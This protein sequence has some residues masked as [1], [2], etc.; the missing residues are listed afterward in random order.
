MSGATTVSVAG[1]KEKSGCTVLDWASAS[2]TRPD[3]ESG[4]GS[5][6]ACGPSKAGASG[7]CRVGPSYLEMRENTEHI[8]FK[9]DSE[10]TFFISLVMCMTIFQ[11]I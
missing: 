10:T 8:L 9:R 7:L 1:L 2:G 6:G 4:A 3:E 11:I 5:C